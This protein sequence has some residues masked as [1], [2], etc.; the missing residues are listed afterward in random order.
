MIREE[1]KISEGQVF[2]IDE[3]GVSAVQTPKMTQCYQN[4]ERM[5]SVE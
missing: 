3:A 5:E 4:E 1:Q 2:D